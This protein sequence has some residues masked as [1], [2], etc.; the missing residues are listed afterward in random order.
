[1]RSATIEDPVHFVFKARLKRYYLPTIP[2]H[3]L[4]LHHLQIICNCG[5]TVLEPPVPCGT[6]IQCSYPCVRHPP[7][8]GHPRAPH[9]CHEDPTPCPPCVVLTEKLCACGKTMVSNIRCS[10]EK[11]SCGKPCGRPL[12]CGFHPC[13]QLCHAGACAPCTAICGKPRKLW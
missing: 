8:C 9:L 12:G 2:S 6:E 4:C 7:P 10:Q 3:R 11:V 5:R 13:E 1:M